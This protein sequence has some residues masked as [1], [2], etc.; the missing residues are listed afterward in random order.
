[1]SKK[2]SNPNTINP[3]QRITEEIRADILA[4]A[5]ARKKWDNVREKTIQ[6][7]LGFLT[8]YGFTDVREEMDN[9]AKVIRFELVVGDNTT[10]G[11][12]SFKDYSPSETSAQWCVGY[13]EL[14]AGR[15]AS[16]NM[17]LDNNCNALHSALDALVRPLVR[18][19]LMQDAEIEADNE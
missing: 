19:T 2:Q 7:L 12:V 11:K 1:M 15:H 8:S 10:Q 5:D 6:Y 9:G 18:Q 14:P 13:I 17:H 4:A 3:I 16:P